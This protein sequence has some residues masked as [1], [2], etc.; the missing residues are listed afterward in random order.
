[1]TEPHDRDWRPAYTSIATHGAETC[2][3]SLQSKCSTD[4]DRVKVFVLHTFGRKTGTTVIL[5]SGTF[6]VAALKKGKPWEVPVEGLLPSW[7]GSDAE[8]W[9]KSNSCTP[10]QW[11]VG[12][13]LCNGTRTRVLGQAGAAAPAAGAAAPAAGAAA[14]AAGAAAPAAGAEMTA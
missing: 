14:P 3:T 13:D 12:I 8:A 11:Q 7:N 10:S 9:A 2:T 5:P 1:M 4:T 6:K